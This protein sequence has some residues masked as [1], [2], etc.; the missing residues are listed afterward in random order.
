MSDV[1]AA[2]LPLAPAL[3]MVA[4]L[5]ASAAQADTMPQRTVTLTGTGIVRAVP[6][7]ATV[8]LGV[9]T[10]ADD[11]ASALSQNSAQMRTLLAA[12]EAAGI[13]KADVATAAVTLEPRIVYPED[14]K[15]QP[16]VTGFSARNAVSVRVRDV[17]KLGA[18]L[19]G[20]V[21][22]GGNELS[23]LAYDFADRGPLLDRARAEAVADAKRKAEAIAAAAGIQL[24]RIVRI[25]EGGADNGFNPQPRMMARAAK[26]DVPVEA[27]TQEVTAEVTITWD[28]AP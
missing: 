5:L 11:A 1:L 28:I 9:R 12:V 24:S 23:S 4:A 21:G 2:R 16:R 18:L 14:D 3:M 8:T 20:A 17:G 25:E 22:A 10:E 27:G 6:D 19:Q 13:A 7:L 15:Q 26:A